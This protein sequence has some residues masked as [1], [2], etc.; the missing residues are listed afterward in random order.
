MWEQL[1]EH[2]DYVEQI[3]F[4]GGEPLL[5]EEHYLILEELVKRNRT[6]VRLI[7]NT[8][9]THVKLK[10][11]SVFEYWKLFD[12]VAIGASLDGSGKHAEY[13]RKGT[14][15]DQVEQNRIDMMRIC[16]QVDFYLSPTLS[17]FN[18]IHL[19]DFHR[20]W[21]E[22]G[23]IQPKDLNINILQDPVHYR[24]DVLPPKYKEKVKEKFEEHLEWLRP[25]DSLNRATIGF[26]SAINF[27]L[28]TDNSHLLEKFWIKTN[29]LDNI[30]S[31]D[32]LSV[33]PELGQLK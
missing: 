23:F 12:S 6:D 24:I 21:V 32:I 26:D 31:E 15:W 25:H 22:K 10:D 9:F 19:P 13:L 30:R 5:M 4:A 17:I 20:D 33:I 27:M 3:Y 18:A 11:K 16:P 1:I 8:N 2:I 14:V 29:Q 28:A 7:Y